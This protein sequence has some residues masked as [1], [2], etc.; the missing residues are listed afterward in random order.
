MDS[1]G[2]QSLGLDVLGGVDL[3]RVQ[4]VAVIFKKPLAGASR[5]LIVATLAR[6]WTD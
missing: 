3:C 1:E 4:S 2:M 6:A 5:R